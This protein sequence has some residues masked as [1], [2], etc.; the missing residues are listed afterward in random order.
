MCGCCGEDELF[1][2]ASPEAA[3][4]E[5]AK[6]MEHWRSPLALRCGDGKLERAFGVEIPQEVYDAHTQQIEVGGDE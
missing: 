4:E 5:L 2:L 1:R 3:R 6:T